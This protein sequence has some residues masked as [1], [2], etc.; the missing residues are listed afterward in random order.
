M[1]PALYVV[2][3]TVLFGGCLLA[4]Y[5]FLCSLQLTLYRIVDWFIVD[6]LH[7]P[8]ADLEDDDE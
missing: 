4:S 2:D 7:G 3:G 1:H 6:I 8:E 5:I